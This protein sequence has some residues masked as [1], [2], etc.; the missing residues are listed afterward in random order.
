MSDLHCAA[1]LLIAR[2]GDAEYGHS[3]VLTD[4]GGWLSEKGIAQAESLA[5]SLATRRIARVHTSSLARA[6]ESGAVAARVLGV[7]TR[8]VPGLEEFSVGALAGRP[9][10]DPELASVVKAWMHGDLGRFIPGGE[11]GEEVIARYREA[12]LSIADQFRGETVLVFSHGGV[13]SFVLPRITGTVRDD[14]T[15]GRFLP[16][17]AVAEVSVDGDG[18]TMRSWPGS[19]DRAVV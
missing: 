11:T 1:T 4:E 7:D 5:A 10:D 18:F 19:S 2:H 6:V 15:A 14:P 17:C 8:V 13:M 9:H 3:S 16:N 12:L